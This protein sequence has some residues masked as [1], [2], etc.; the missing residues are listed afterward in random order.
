MI[1][2]S[3]VVGCVAALL[4]PA[5]VAGAADTRLVQAVREQDR[6]AVR[7]LLERKVDVNAPRCTG[8]CAPTMQS[9]SRG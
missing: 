6:A 3:F 9:W 7:S 8:P 4:L 1:E 5:G 2:K